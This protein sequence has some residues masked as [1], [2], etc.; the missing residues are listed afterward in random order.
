M[1]RARHV[2]ATE[3]RELPQNRVGTTC[4]SNVSESS[5][6]AST[7]FDC[8]S[9]RD[10]AFQV[11]HASSFYVH[12]R[13]EY[14]SLVCSRQKKVITSD[15]KKLLSTFLSSMWTGFRGT[16]LQWAFLEKHHWLTA[17]RNQTWTKRSFGLL[18]NQ[19][20]VN[21]STVW[22]RSCVHVEFRSAGR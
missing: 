8:G 17:A 16:L 2:G 15:G 13:S 3:E 14:L 20:H 10:T 7:C 12:L 5:S 1:A 21:I 22:A 4:K 19:G 9:D 6:P 11:V 18:A